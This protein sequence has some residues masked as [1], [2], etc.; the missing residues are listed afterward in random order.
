MILLTL[1]ALFACVCIFL[2]DSTL[3]SPE[4]TKFIGTKNPKVARIVCILAIIMYLTVVVLRKLV[5][6]GKL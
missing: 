4:I 1:V 5:D 6:A 2:P 3:A